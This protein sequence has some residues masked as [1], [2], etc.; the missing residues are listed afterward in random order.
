MEM[1]PRFTAKGQED[2]KIEFMRFDEDTT[3]MTVTDRDGRQ[4]TLWMNEEGLDDLLN[5]AVDAKQSRPIPSADNLRLKRKATEQSPKA[6]QGPRAIE[7]P[8]PES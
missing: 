8:Q 4:V 7:A 2:S 3:G 6:E 1:Y 5:K